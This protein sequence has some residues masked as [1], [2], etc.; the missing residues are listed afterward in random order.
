MAAAVP[1]RAGVVLVAL[2][3]ALVA[4]LSL[5]NSG[6]AL[7]SRLV[8]GEF[9][10]SLLILVFWLVLGGVL[11]VAAIG[12]VQG[13]Q[14]ALIVTLAALVLSVLLSVADLVSSGF[15]VSAV[16]AAILGLEVVALVYLIRIRD[17]FV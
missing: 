5:L 14:W 12:L 1:T 9:G 15:R 3:I 6:A 11:L 8:G 13:W 4:I 16:A 10:L 2:L 7:L 17:E